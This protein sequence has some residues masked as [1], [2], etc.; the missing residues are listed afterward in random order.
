MPDQRVQEHVRNSQFVVAGALERLGASNVSVVEDSP[1]L[2]IFKIDEILHGPAVLSGFAGKSITVLL[3]DVATARVGEPLILF[4]QSW[5]YGESLAVV[6]VARIEDKERKAMKDEIAEAHERLADERL[7]RR[8]ELA[9]LIVVGK[10]AAIAPFPGNDSLPITE[11]APLYQVATIEIES[12][13][14]GS[15]EGRKLSVLFPSSTDAAWHDSPKFS[16]GQDGVWLIQRD[17]QERG[18][19]KLRVPGLTA[20]DPLDFHPK[21]RAAHIRALIKRGSR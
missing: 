13:E 6:E 21:S 11:H 16:L 19:P 5:L 14:K 1:N 9:E 8:I 4:A 15:H 3:A 12:V 20:L 2:G 17:Q 18:W 7:L 10:V